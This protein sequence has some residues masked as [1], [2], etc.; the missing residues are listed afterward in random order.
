[1]NLTVVLL[2]RTL[3]INVMEEEEGETC[4]MVCF[5]VDVQSFWGEELSRLS[6][7]RNCIVYFP[8]NL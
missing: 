7:L 3:C 5:A 4:I 1:M 6:Y 2:I 8:C